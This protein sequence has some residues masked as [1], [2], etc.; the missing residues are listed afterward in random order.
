MPH[1]I[2]LCSR[3]SHEYDLLAVTC[4]TKPIALI[5]LDCLLPQLSPGA[6][7]A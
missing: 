5:M 2:L 6:R 4:L 1:M 3:A 7:H